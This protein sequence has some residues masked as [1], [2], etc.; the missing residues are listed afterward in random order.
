MENQTVNTNYVALQPPY[1]VIKHGNKIGVQIGIQR[2]VIAGGSPFRTET[3]DYPVVADE[4]KQTALDNPRF[5]VDASCDSKVWDNVELS[6][7]SVLCKLDDHLNWMDF[8]RIVWHDHSRLGD[9]RA[10]LQT[11]YIFSKLLKYFGSMELIAPGHYTIHLLTEPKDGTPKVVCSHREDV[12][13]LNVEWTD[14]LD[15]MEQRMVGGILEYLTIL[16]PNSGRKWWRMIYETDDERLRP[17]VDRLNQND[18]ATRFANNIMASFTVK[19]IPPYVKMT[20]ETS[21]AATVLTTAAAEQ[22]TKE[23]KKRGRKQ[24]EF[25]EFLYTNAPEGL[26]PVL[27]EMMD[28]AS[29]RKALEIILAITDVYMYPPTIVSICRRFNTVGENAIGEALAKTRGGTWGRKDFSD[30]P[31]PVKEADLERIRQEIREKLDER[32]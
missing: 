11:N 2:I 29:G 26:M 22:E 12:L 21:P 24:K 3:H 20:T 30:K 4:N 6:Q 16:A 17:L 18:K 19:C 32:D 15:D 8:I 27:E 13:A 5:Q 7:V 25:E 9:T 10:K 31:S 14:N 1:K 23:K 28:G